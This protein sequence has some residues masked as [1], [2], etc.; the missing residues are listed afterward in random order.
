MVSGIFLS[1]AKRGNPITRSVKGTTNWLRNINDYFSIHTTENFRAGSDPS[2][3][4][5]LQTY[6]TLHTFSGG[7]TIGCP[8]LQ[9][10]ALA[11]S[12]IFTTT[13]LIRNFEGE[14][15]SVSARSRI[16]SGRVFEQSHCA[17]PM[18]KRCSGV[19]PSTGFRS[20]SFVASFHAI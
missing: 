18:K 11:K 8:A 2:L 9:E 13:P 16:S 4:S 5:G 19:S 15:G 10:N 3:R 20:L 7:F 17:K 12:G 14:C 6:H 1:R